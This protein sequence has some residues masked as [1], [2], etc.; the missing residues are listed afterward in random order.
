MS[1][2]FGSP[3]M[4][5]HWRMASLVSRQCCGVTPFGV[6]GDAPEVEGGAVARDSRRHRPADARLR[7]GRCGRLRMKASAEKVVC[8]CR[9][10]KRICFGAGCPAGATRA[11]AC[12]SFCA[13][14]ATTAAGTALPLISPGPWCSPRQPATVSTAA[15]RAMRVA[16][17]ARHFPAVPSAWRV[18]AGC[19]FPSRRS[20]TQREMPRPYKLSMFSPSRWSS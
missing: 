10:P 9:S 4:A 15:R 2:F 6:V 11:A 1:G 20:A 3:A 12:C 13:R 7:P 16:I 5:L 18:W 8:T 19:V 14:A 17:G